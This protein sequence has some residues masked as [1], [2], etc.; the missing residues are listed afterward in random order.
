M[1]SVRTHRAVHQPRE[2]NVWKKSLKSSN[3][4]SCVEVNV[5]A[6]LDAVQVRDTKLG[7]GSPVLTFTHKE[8]DAFLDGARSG[9]FNL[10]DLAVV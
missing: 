2:H 10:A 3:N 4:G 8:W 6:G 7:E 9:E 1:I 5:A